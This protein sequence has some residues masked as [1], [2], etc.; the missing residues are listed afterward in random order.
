MTPGERLLAD[1]THTAMTV[2]AHPMKLCRPR[3]SPKVWSAARLEEAR[4]GQRVQV[5]GTIICRQRPG[6]AKGICFVTL[7]DETGLTNAIVRPELYER[8]RLT[9]SM[10]PAVVITGKV[11]R[12]EGVVHIIAERIAAL[13]DLPNGGSHDWH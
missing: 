11:Q 2:G 8:E 4:P 5:A 3:L 7:E 10:E 12:S 13:P 6:T 1:F 9:L